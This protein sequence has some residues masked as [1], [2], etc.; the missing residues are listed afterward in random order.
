MMAVLL[1]AAA[2]AS[3]GSGPY[4]TVLDSDTELMVFPESHVVL[5]GCT[6]CRNDSSP[7]MDG[8][9]SR[10]QG[11]SGCS[12]GR[13]EPH[14]IFRTGIPNAEC[15]AAL[16]EAGAVAF[17]AFPVVDAVA[18]M[19][20][21]ELACTGDFLDGSRVMASIRWIED[22]VLH[23]KA[24][25]RFFEEMGTDWNGMEIT[26]PFTPHYVYHGSNSLNEDVSY[27][28]L[29]CQQDCSGGLVCNNR[30]PCCRPVPVMRPLWDVIPPVGTT[31]TLVLYV[32]PER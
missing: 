1:M 4:D 2:L 19:Q 14:F 23:E 10:T 18:R 12:D 27:G 31:V 5:I 20:S 29:V 28:C 24:F 7:G 16:I 25:E 22:G 8:F 15:D 13:N 17:N 21:G 32:M 30:G 26:K 9:S 3:T 11:W 6:V